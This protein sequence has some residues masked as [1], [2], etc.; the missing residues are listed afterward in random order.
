MRVE[1]YKIDSVQFEALTLGTLPV[2]THLQRLA[3]F[4]GHMLCSFVFFLFFR[5]I[6]NEM[7]CGQM[8]TLYRVIVV[9]CI[10]SAVVSLYTSMWNDITTFNRVVTCLDF[11]TMRNDARHYTHHHSPRHVGLPCGCGSPPERRHGDMVWWELENCLQPFCT[12][13]WLLLAIICT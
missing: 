8:Y 2:T 5:W 12:F 1:K 10:W 9:F 3:T 11:G 6:L 13:N 7:L 4:F